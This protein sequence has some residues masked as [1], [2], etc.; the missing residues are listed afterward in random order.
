M[1]IVIQNFATVLIDGVN[2]GSIVDAIRNHA[3]KAPAIAAAAVQWNAE[4]EQRIGAIETAAAERIAAAE[5]ATKDVTAARDAAI[6]E[7]DA[8]RAEVAKSNNNILGA[9]EAG[10]AVLD[11]LRVLSDSHAQSLQSIVTFA[12]GALAQLRT[13]TESDAI[14]RQKELADALAAKQAAEAKIAEL[15][16]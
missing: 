15:Q 8:A 12:I 13:A 7:R 3:D 6:A 5:Q 2:A 10:Q 1:A 14:A 11:R 16:A 9:R 4:Y